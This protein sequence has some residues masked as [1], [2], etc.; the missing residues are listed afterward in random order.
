M[1]HEF[2]NEKKKMIRM[3]QQHSFGNQNIDREN[4]NQQV[5][6]GIC[7]QNQIVSPNQQEFQTTNFIQPPILGLS[8]VD[9]TQNQ[10]EF[11]MNIHGNSILQGFGIMNGFN[12]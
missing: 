3:T 4:Y 9:P 10:S 12:P 2:L 8:S 7:F 1:F 11:T 5:F 6:N